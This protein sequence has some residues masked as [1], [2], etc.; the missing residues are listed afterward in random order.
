MTKT[1]FTKELSA[2][3]NRACL[4]NDSNTP[5][6][7]LAEYLM[8]VLDAYARVTTKRDEWWGLKPW[9]KAGVPK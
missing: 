2:L 9:A 3:L 8:D 4:E 1:D 5:D 7:I 6:Y